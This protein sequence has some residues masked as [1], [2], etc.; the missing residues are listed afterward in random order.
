MSI[1]KEQNMFE[2]WLDINYE[3]LEL[4]YSENG[5]DFDY[6]QE[7][8][9][10]EF[11]EIITDLFET[12]QCEGTACEYCEHNEVTRDAYGTGDSPTM[13]E[14]TTVEPSNCYFV[15]DNLHETALS[16]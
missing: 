6:F 3:N 14:C 16:L 8:V 2:E 13:R 5:G 12:A 11:D 10:E 9:R 15:V 4:S 1:E 7:F